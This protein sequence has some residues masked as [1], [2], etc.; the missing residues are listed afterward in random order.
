MAKR[1]NSANITPRSSLY[2]VWVPLH[3]DGKAPLI[4]IW[5]DLTTTVVDPR[6]RHYGIGS[7][8]ASDGAIVEEPCAA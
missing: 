4:S 7:R 6:Q 3:N 2:R 5:I 8:G 1:K